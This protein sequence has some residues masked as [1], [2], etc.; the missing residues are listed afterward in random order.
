MNG[1]DVVVP[2]A[3]VAVTGGV[4]IWSKIIDARSKR[5]D[6]QH[7]T[8]LDYE[9]RSGEDK[10]AV[11]RMLIAATLHVKE[12]AQLRGDELTEEVTDDTQRRRKA[13]ATSAL[14]EFRNQLDVDGRIAE[15]KAYAAEPVSQLVDA[16]L[17]EADRQ[18]GRCPLPLLSIDR[19]RKEIADLRNARKSGNDD[20]T[21]DTYHMKWLELTSQEDRWLERISQDSNLDVD[22]LLDLCDR[23]YRAA[24]K[25][26]RGEYG[27][28]E[29]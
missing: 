27:G 4:A 29:G 17:V 10:K 23:T 19:T 22:W 7:A 13:R 6:R 5:E 18:F 12:Q 11:L 21:V 24:R 14:F 28:T 20:M 15:L 26:L 2:V 1:W 16:M 25:D 9:R 8:A 3:S